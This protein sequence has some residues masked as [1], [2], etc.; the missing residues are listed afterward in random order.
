METILVIAVV[1]LGLWNFWLHGQVKERSI[2][3]KTARIL[4]EWKLGKTK[5][6]ESEFKDI[7]GSGDEGGCKVLSIKELPYSEIKWTCACGHKGKDYAYFLQAGI[8]EH[9]E[10]MSLIGK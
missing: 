5:A 7:A 10:R 3:A 2:A 9:K 6:W 1:G 4:R 8:R